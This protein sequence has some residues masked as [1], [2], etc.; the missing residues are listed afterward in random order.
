MCKGGMTVTE[1]L[2]DT[3]LQ[4]FSRSSKNGVSGRSSGLLLSGKSSHPKR[5]SDVRLPFLW[6]ITAAGTAPDYTPDSH[7]KAQNT[8]FCIHQRGKNSDK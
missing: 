3:H 2:S 1:E 5:D 4:L 8:Q 7:I 6:R